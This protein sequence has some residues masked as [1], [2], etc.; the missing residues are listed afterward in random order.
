MIDI[1]P[2]GFP[3][4]ANNHLVASDFSD[5]QFID[6]KV[7]RM[8]CEF[9]PYSFAKGGVRSRITGQSLLMTKSPLVRPDRNFAYLVNNHYHTHLPVAD[10]STGVL[11]YKFIGAFRN[12]IQEA[13]ERREHFQG[14]RF[15]RKFA[16][17][18]ESPKSL[19]ASNGLI[20]YEGTRQLI[21][22]GFL[23]SSKSWDEFDG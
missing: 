8:P 15:Y 20:R 7:L 22:L 5:C 1:V 11:H 17:C 12:R 13:I 16:G 3:R 18:L 6:P 10:V 4:H 19:L 23:V 2:E 14:A 21:S 9:P